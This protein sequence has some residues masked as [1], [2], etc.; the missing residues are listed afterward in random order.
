MDKSALREIYK[1]KRNEL[2]SDERREASK[3]IALNLGAKWDFNQKTISCFL[4]IQ[5][6]NEVNTAPLMQQ[7]GIKNNLCAPV[8]DFSNTTMIHRLIDDATLIKH[9][10]WSIPEPTNGT[11]VRPEVLDVVIVPLL[12]SDKK[13]YRVGYGKGF[14]DRFLSQ[15]NKSC[16]FIGINYFEPISVITGTHKNDI[17][18]HFTVTPSSIIEHEST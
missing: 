12:I 7:L 1:K 10:D 8:A 2:T 9:N 5:R 17:A 15:C 14:Y 13:G 11:I 16:L 4:P 3:K 6:L 18:L